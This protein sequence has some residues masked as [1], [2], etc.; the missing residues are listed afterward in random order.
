MPFDQTHRRAF[1][2]LLGGAAATWPLAARAVEGQGGGT[3]Y[4]RIFQVTPSS[5]S[6]RRLRACPLPASLRV[7]KP[8]Q[9][10][11]WLGE[12]A[13]RVRRCTD[14]SPHNLALAFGCRLTSLEEE[15]CSSKWRKLWTIGGQPLMRS[16]H[17]KSVHQLPFDYRRQYPSLQWRR[18]IR[19]GHV[20]AEH[21]I[22]PAGR[23]MRAD[24]LAQEKYV[25]AVT[26]P[27]EETAIDAIEGL[28]DKRRRKLAQARWLEATLA[29]ARKDGFVDI[30]CNDRKIDMRKI[31]CEHDRP[32]SRFPLFP[33]R[34]RG[35]FGQ[36]VISQ[37]FENGPVAEEA[38]DREPPSISFLGS[39]ASI[40]ANALFTLISE[41]LPS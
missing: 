6:P 12:G 1:I 41:M 22:E 13:D 38:G 25:L 4:D 3:E 34:T 8:R 2:T 14:F 31:P 19:K 21:E 23:R 5:P 15:R 27:Q 28:R 40:R 36:Y 32:K 20:A 33:L 26:R 9:P 16:D 30:R 7:A 10:G 18:E 37:Q 29:C 17:Q 11:A 35:N 39:V 24:I